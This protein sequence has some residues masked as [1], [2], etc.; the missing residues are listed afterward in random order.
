VR[1]RLGGRATI[2]LHDSD[3]AAAPGAWRAT[4]NALPGLLEHCADRG[5]AVGPLA[6]HDIRAPLTWATSWPID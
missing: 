6:E 3:I 5:L 2:L 4:L 1:H